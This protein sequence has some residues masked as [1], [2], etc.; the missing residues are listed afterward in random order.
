MRLEFV[1]L[2]TLPFS[3]TGIGRARQGS[4]LVP[5]RTMVSVFGPL[6]GPS[7]TWRASEPV[8][9]L[10]PCG[11]NRHLMLFNL[12]P[13]FRVPLTAYLDATSSPGRHDYSYGS[14][15]PLSCLSSSEAPERDY[16]SRLEVKLSLSQDFSSL[17]CLF[18]T[19]IS[20]TQ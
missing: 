1:L 10:S 13:H 18:L 3:V 19:I 5:A 8:L 15:L 17:G 2:G 9:P 7:R 6:F 20:R 12:E 11:F 16:S 14:P 4:T